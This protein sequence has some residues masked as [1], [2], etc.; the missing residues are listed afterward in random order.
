MEPGIGGSLRERPE[1]APS[2]KTLFGLYSDKETLLFTGTLF[3][4]TSRESIPQLLSNDQCHKNILSNFCK[5]LLTS[6]IFFKNK[7]C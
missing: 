3:N 6:F 4:N 2:Q 7:Q 5:Q 1:G